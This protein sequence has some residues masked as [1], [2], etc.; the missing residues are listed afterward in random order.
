MSRVPRLPLVPVV[1]RPGRACARE[2]PTGKVPGRV[3]KLGVLRIAGL[4][5]RLDVPGCT[6]IRGGVMSTLA[7]EAVVM[8]ARPRS[9]IVHECRLVRGS[10][11]EP[12]V[13]DRTTG[14]A[15]LRSGARRVGGTTVVRFD[16]LPVVSTGGAAVQIRYGPSAS[17][18][19]PC[20][21]GEACGR[22]RAHSRRAQ[23][24]IPP[25]CLRLPSPCRGGAP[26]GAGAGIHD[27]RAE[28]QERADRTHA[29]PS[30]HLP[31]PRGERGAE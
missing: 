13:T 3:R 19:V 29:E 18:S 5:G 22:V 31:R 2:V 6:V 25:P 8:P 15:R 20:T 27:Q 4:G 9:V 17:R 30:H 14:R 26:S 12:A 28:G 7:V 11:S 23:L 1:G 16:G 10:R 21:S 24:R